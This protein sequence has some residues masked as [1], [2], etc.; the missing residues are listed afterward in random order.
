MKICPTLRARRGRVTG[1]GGGCLATGAS[2]GRAM[3]RPASRGGDTDHRQRGPGGEKARSALATRH[4]IEAYNA[5]WRKAWRGQASWCLPTTTP[6]TNTTAALWQGR[7]IGLFHHGHGEIG[8]RPAP[9][10]REG[11]HR[12]GE[13]RNHYGCGGPL[14]HRPPAL[15]AGRYTLRLAKPGLPAKTVEVEVCAGKRTKV[16]VVL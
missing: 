5:V 16:E 10:W 6:N 11:D 7:K 1:S 3:G 8:Q 9:R 15:P 12:L 2:A 13:H 14:R 4:R